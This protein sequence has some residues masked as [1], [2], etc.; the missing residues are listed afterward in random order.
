MKNRQ[1]NKK[2]TTKLKKTK[3]EKETY[4]VPKVVAKPKLTKEEIKQINRENNENDLFNT[5]I[6]NTQKLSKHDLGV[7]NRPEDYPT[8]KKDRSYNYGVQR[9]KDDLKLLDFLLSNLKD[10]YKHQIVGSGEF[11]N[12]IDK[13]MGIDEWS[14][15]P[16]EDEKKVMVLLASKMLIKS[17]TVIQRNMPHQF[18]EVLRETG[19]PFFTMI[20]AL[21]D[22]GKDNNLK[23]IP[24]IHLP[25]S[26]I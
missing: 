8:A 3:K 18:S 23:S 17:L 10:R 13:Y 26:L 16:S 15:E 6:H 12:I 4:S 21:N 11:G 20:K 7:I 24:P 2:N 9:A 25:N 22:F 5:W 14:D 19:K 1:G